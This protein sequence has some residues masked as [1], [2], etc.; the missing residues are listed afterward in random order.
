[1]YDTQAPPRSVFFTSRPPEAAR[2]N[3]QQSG[4]TR[5]RVALPKNADE[6]PLWIGARC[7][8]QNGLKQT[9]MQFSSTERWG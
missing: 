5:D 7:S 3:R 8:E 1:M 2:D 9:K 6:T 4:L